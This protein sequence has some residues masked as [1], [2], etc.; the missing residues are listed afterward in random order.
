MPTKKR[1][2]IF[3]IDTNIALDYI[4]ARNRQTI[5]VLTK[6]KEKG[7]KCISSS[8][9]SME[10][11]DYKKDSLFVIEKAMD[12]K[13]E[14]RKILREVYKKD[15]KLGDF[16]KVDA[17]IDEFEIEY[18]NFQMYDFLVS[19]D[20]WLYAQYISRYSN[21]NSTDALHLTSAILACKNNAC[22]IMITNDKHL[23]IEGE[24]ML[25]PLKSGLKILNTIDVERQF[26]TRKTRITK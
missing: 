22:Q 12:R 24:K 7:W 23:K 15:L 1:N 26:F 20:D 5:D 11:A 19:N 9:L 21:L 6:I 4:T 16:Q 25:K 17:W 2:K 14:I 13:W 8:F 10:L 3:Y 18:K